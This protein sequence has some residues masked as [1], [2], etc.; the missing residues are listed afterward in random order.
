MFRCAFSVL[1]ETHKIKIKHLHLVTI[2]STQTIC[3]RNLEVKVRGVTCLPPKLHTNTILV[4]S[5]TK[6]YIKLY[7]N[8]MQVGLE[9]LQ[10]QFWAL[11]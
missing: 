2:P 6:Q 7:I 3:P 1:I 11:T 10:I 9:H 4:I 5:T 8:A